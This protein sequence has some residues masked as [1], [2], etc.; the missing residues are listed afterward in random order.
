VRYF[1]LSS[2]FKR[3]HV[4]V[5]FKDAFE[6]E[7]KLYKFSKNPLATMFVTSNLQVAFKGTLYYI[8]TYWMGDR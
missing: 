7:L 3:H 6:K 8:G 5:R 4:D 2:L 1:P